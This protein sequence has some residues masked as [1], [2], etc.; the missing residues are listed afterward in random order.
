[1]SDFGFTEVTKEQTQVLEALRE[2]F[3]N[4][5]RFLTIVCP[6]RERPAAQASPCR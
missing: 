3:E 5:E 4:L 6:D 2:R 1:M